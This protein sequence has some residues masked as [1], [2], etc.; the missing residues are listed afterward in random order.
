MVP[1]TKLY[2]I[3]L[4]FQFLTHLLL[5]G[6]TSTVLRAWTQNHPQVVGTCPGHHPQPIGKNRDFKFERP[7]PPLMVS[8]QVQIIKESV[9][10]IIHYPYF[11][12][13]IIHTSWDR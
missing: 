1:I 13:H 4:S 9:I 7:G 6:L 12:L 11:N 8:L 2:V 10:Y 5:Q 3:L